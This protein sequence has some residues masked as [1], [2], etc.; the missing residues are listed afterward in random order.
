MKVYHP[1][2]CLK[3]SQKAW[4]FFVYNIWIDWPSYLVLK[5]VIT[6]RKIFRN[7][8]KNP[9]SRSD[10]ALASCLIFN[11]K[12]LFDLTIELP[13]ASSV[14]CMQP[15]SLISFCHSLFKLELVY[16]INQKQRKSR[17]PI[18]CHLTIAD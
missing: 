15:G 9:I 14:E 2:K 6:A 13:V 4:I 1:L 10:F 5:V 7:K 18:P 17:A 12:D 16:I 3:R 11:S 8:K